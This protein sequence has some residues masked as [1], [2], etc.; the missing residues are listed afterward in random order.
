VSLSGVYYGGKKISQSAQQ[1]AQ[2]DPV[3]SSDPNSDRHKWIKITGSI[4][5]GV[6]TGVSIEFST[7]ENIAQQRHGNSWD[8]VARECNLKP[9]LDS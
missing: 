5:V 7:W 1:P 3:K 8:D 4:R 9:V 6:I 2:V